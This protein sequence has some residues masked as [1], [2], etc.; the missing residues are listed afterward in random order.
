M[1]DEDLI[2]FCDRM[3]KENEAGIST[4]AFPL[5]NPKAHAWLTFARACAQRH[6]QS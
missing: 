2:A 4:R 1:R 3:K 5:E 6:M